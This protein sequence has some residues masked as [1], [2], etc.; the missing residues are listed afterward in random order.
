MDKTSE[1]VAH[2]LIRAQM[3]Q[4]LA[5]DVGMKEHES[6][7]FLLGLF[8]M[9]DV[10]VGR[11]LVQILDEIGLA[12]EVKVALL[13]ERTEYGD[14]YELVISYERGQWE[15]YSERTSKLHFEPKQILDTYVKAAEWADYIAGEYRSH[16]STQRA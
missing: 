2:S 8:S 4:T 10:L 14:L 6:E 1:V 13:G 9:V 5:G 12:K 11:P 16:G 3:C 7:L 15:K